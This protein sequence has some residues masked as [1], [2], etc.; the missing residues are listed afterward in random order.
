MFCFIL[1]FPN[2]LFLFIPQES[3][4]DIRFDKLAVGFQNQIDELKIQ[5]IRL[6]TVK[7]TNSIDK[8]ARGIKKRQTVSKK[9]KTYSSICEISASVCTFYHPD[10]PDA[11]NRKISTNASL[12]NRL[13]AK[14]NTKPSAVC[15][16]SASLCT[17]YH[18][19]HHNAKNLKNE[20]TVEMTNGSTTNIWATNAMTTNRPPVIPTEIIEM[21]V[22]NILKVKGMPTSCK[23]LQLI[24]H[25]LNGLYLVKTNKPERG[26]KIEAV[27]CDFQSTKDVINGNI[28]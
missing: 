17:F 12:G 19:D 8:P 6:K 3:I 21:S 27:F 26:T 24:G 5:V 7:G 1:K 11:N 9:P 2:W 13:E 16:S 23:E 10:Y 18:P 28:S 15:E 20:T 22:Q 4:V 14:K 25:T